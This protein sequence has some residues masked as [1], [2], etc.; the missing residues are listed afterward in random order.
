MGTLSKWL[1][2]DYLTK[3]IDGPISNILIGLSGTGG[4]LTK[5][6]DPELKKAETANVEWVK[7]IL[8]DS[9]LS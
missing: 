4:T 3:K 1:R 7:D 8:Y 5:N 9:K 6:T 2:I